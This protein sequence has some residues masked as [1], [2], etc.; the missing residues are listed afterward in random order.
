MQRQYTEQYQIDD[1]YYANVIT[2]NRFSSA[3]RDGVTLI[4]TLSATVTYVMPNDY[5]D[6]FLLLPHVV[7]KNCYA[8]I[9]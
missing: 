7:Q 3:I 6:N 1:I 5:I 2:S 8:H 9:Y 4:F